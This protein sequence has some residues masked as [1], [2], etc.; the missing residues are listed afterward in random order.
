MLSNEDGSVGGFVEI[1]VATE[2][3]V[4][5]RIDGAILTKN[6][7]ERSVAQVR[8]VPPGFFKPFLDRAIY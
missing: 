7:G 4:D 1:F 2:G 8:A 3:Y 5:E 6:V